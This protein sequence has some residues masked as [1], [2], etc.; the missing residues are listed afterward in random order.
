MELL[1]IKEFCQEWKKDLTE[2]VARLSQAPTLSI[3]QVGDNEASNRYVRNKVKDC[4]EVGILAK[5]KLFD[6][7]ITTDELMEMI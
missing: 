6:E 2:K 1:N 3:Y 4:D 5:V 7:S